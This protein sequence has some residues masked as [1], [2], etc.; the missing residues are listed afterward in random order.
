MIEPLSSSTATAVM[1][2]WCRMVGP[3]SLETPSALESKDQ[4]LW[5][6]ARSCGAAVRLLRNAQT[7]CTRTRTG[8]RVRLDAMS[9]TYPATMTIKRKRLS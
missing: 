1:N 5:V 6:T 8:Y 4:A 7:A 2:N 3:G 9:I